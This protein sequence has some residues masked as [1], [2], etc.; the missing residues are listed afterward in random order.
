MFDIDFCLAFR[1]PVQSVFITT[2]QTS[3]KSG[4]ICCIELEN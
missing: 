4:G 1:D 3:T 2:R